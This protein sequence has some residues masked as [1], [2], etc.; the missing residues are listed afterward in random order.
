[1]N[2]DLTANK[3]AESIKKVL[4]EMAS[5]D[6]LPLDITELNIEKIKMVIMPVFK[7]ILVLE[8]DATIALEGGYDLNQPEGLFQNQIKLI[9]NL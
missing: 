9:N 8:K 2:L 4:I 5:K 3:Y 1:M 6:E 7:A